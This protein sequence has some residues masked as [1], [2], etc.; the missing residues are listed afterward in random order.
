[1]FK[2]ILLP[3]D[4]QES[5]LSLRATQIAQEFA[6]QYDARI[7][8]I[9][10][11]PN[12]G[13]PIVANF[14]P[15]NT[16]KNAAN[17]VLSELKR[18]VAAHFDKPENVSVHVAEGSPHEEILEFAVRHGSDLIIVPARGKNIEKIFLGSSSIQIVE[19]SKCTVMV[20][21]P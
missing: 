8:V 17:E 16:I 14:F 2:E 15:A 12:F 6:D 18:F 3:V 19:Q 7:T 5:A 1:M 10:V 21:R 9:T 4:L 13:M 11:I 20:V